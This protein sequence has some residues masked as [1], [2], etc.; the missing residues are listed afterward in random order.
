MSIF[1]SINISAS[2]LNSERTRMDTISKNIANANTTRTSAGTP[3]RRQLAVF[4]EDGEVSFDSILSKAK[5][6]TESSGG[7]KITGIVEDQSEFKLVYD[8]GHPDARE[9]GYVEMPN[10]D[11]VR[12]MVDMITATRAYEANLTSI[13]TAKSMA[14]KAIDIGK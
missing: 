8:P 14:M 3:Y 6:S 4:Q 5:E 7:V 10:V 13:N 9:D 2:G 12:E 11:I 1:S